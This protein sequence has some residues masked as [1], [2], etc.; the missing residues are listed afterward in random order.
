[1]NIEIHNFTQNEVDSNIFNK[2]ADNTLKFLGIDKEIEIS[3]ALIGDGRMRRLNKLYRGKNRVTDVLS[4]AEKSVLKYLHRAF[5]RLK[6]TDQTEDFVLPP[7]NINRIGEIV[8]C[9]P[10]AKKQAKRQ[11]HTLEKELSILMSHGLLHLLFVVHEQDEKKR[12]EMEAVEAKILK[13]LY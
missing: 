8:I 7:D 5:P 3:L 13:I 4:F 1:M 2:A 11:G 10:Q 9:L 12:Q 6:K